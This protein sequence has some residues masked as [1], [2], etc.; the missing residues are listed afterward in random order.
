V[1]SSCRTQITWYCSSRGITE[2]RNVIQ[3]K[4]SSNT[5]IPWLNNH[6]LIA[7][8]LS[9]WLA[10]HFD[11]VG[12][13]LMPSFVANGV[14]RRAGGHVGRRDYAGPL[15]PRRR[16]HHFRTDPEYQASE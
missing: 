8:T 2:E 11:V 1:A 3:P 7:E 12:M 9:I 15:R 14:A 6:S 16:P 5:R 10:P 13:I 4:H